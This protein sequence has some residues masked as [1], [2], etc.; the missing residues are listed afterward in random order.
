MGNMKI[1]TRLY[2]SFAAIVAIVI[3]LVV[4]ARQNFASL[5]DA[6]RWNIHTYQVME[7]TNSM[8]T[9][10]INMETGQ[11]GFL[12]AGRDE[13]LE[14]YRGGQVAFREHFDKAK[15]LTS[16]NP[17]QQERFAKILV[18]QQAWV[19]EVL[20]P[21]IALRRAVEEGRGDFQQ[22]IAV[23]QEAKGKKYMDNLRA[24]VK[25]VLDAESGL[26]VVRAKEAEALHSSTISVLIGGG[27]LAVALASLVAFLITR[28]IVRPMNEAVRAL[29]RLADGDL[30]VRVEA[31]T[32]DETGQLLNAMQIMVGKLSDVVTGVNQAADSITSASEQVSTTAQSLSQASSEQAASVEETSASMEQM[33]SSITQNTENAKVTD[34]M[35][36]KASSEANEGGEAVRATVSAMKQIAQK[37]GIIDDIA[38]QTNLL[39]LNAAIEA[40]RAGEH[41]KGFA[42]VAAEVRKLAERSQVAAQEIST[43][44]TES[45][46]LAERAGKLLDTIV[47]SIQKTSDLVQEISAASGEQSTGVSQINTAIMQ[48]NKVTQQNA[49]SSEELAATAEEMTGQ[50]EELQSKMRFFKIDSEVAVSRA[51]RPKAVHRAKQESFEE[52]APARRPALATNGN[53]ALVEDALA[54]EDFKRF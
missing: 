47:P 4:V 9:S 16:D 36:S 3:A 35:A 15:N 7:E 18:A 44:A 34:S 29:E 48:L 38:Y 11:R 51:R 32:K 2:L 8:L 30:T 52:Q 26:L 12:L 17:Q 31:T 41:G 37:I 49:S 14:P 53:L 13:F 23:V 33:S 6:N 40:A 42:V 5:T 39:A 25:E 1:G 24:N 45:V 20:E 22:I 21:E 19:T 10:L 27:L 43:V 50:A 28:S 46:G 54:E